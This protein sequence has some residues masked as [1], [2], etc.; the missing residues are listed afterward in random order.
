MKDIREVLQRKEQE[1]QKLQREIEVL[2]AAATILEDG[3]M[4]A[5]S[6]AAGRSP[7]TSRGPANVESITPEAAK[8]AFP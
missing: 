4:L 5:T 7:V 2:R 3:E 1:I 6:S 8:R